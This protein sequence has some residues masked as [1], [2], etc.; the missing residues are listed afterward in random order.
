MSQKT[1]RKGIVICQCMLLHCTYSRHSRLQ[2]SM[3]S[4]AKLGDNAFYFSRGTWRIS[5]PFPQTVSLKNNAF[6]SVIGNPG[7]H[8]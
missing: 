6:G 3:A 2:G 7:I 5:Y 1:V 8:T 4:A